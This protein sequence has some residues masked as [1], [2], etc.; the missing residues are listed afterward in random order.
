MRNPF[1][2]MRFFRGA[3]EVQRDSM[4]HEVCLHSWQY[5]PYTDVLYAVV[6][7]YIHIEL[8]LVINLTRQKTVN[9]RKNRD[10]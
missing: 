5:F 7:E 3:T 1:F 9:G 10:D 4:P 6:A 8:V 2:Y